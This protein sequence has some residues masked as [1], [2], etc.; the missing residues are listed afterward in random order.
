VSKLEFLKWKFC[1]GLFPFCM[2]LNALVPTDR[3]ANR[4][5][6]LNVGLIL[7]VWKRIAIGMA[8][9]GN[10]V[11]NQAAPFVEHLNQAGPCFS[12]ILILLLGNFRREIPQVVVVYG[13]DT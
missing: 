10:E 8:E 12:I 1:D 7:P 6:H 5:S 4:M 2:K 9:V 3:L 13:L 11:A